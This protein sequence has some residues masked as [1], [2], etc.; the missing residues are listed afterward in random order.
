MN[1][2]ISLVS[3]ELPSVTVVWIV[4]YPENRHASM[5]RRDFGDFRITARPHETI[6]PTDG[7]D[8]GVSGFVHHP[9]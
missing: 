7:L 4:A 2:F 3:H 9:G 6:P 8:F 1:S 5:S